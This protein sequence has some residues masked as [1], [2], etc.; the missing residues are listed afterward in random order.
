MKISLVYFLLSLLFVV[1]IGI[2]TMRSLFSS[3]VGEYQEET[4]QSE[5]QFASLGKSISLGDY[6]DYEDEE[7]KGDNESDKE[8][9]KVNI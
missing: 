1:A 4:L 9:K 6:Q 2:F 7:S 5:E 3:T 8:G